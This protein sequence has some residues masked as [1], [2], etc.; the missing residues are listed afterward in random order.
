MNDDLRQ[1]SG[2]TRYKEP[3]GRQPAAPVLYCLRLPKPSEENKAMNR[4]TILGLTA[5]AAVAIAAVAPASAGVKFYFGA[6]AY[7]GYAPYYPP[8]YYQPYYAPP[9]YSCQWVIVGYKTVWNGYAWVKVPK[10]QKVC[11]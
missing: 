11:N 4:T 5:A 3:H 2:S 7:S 9:V 1:R 6:P 10:K 8:T